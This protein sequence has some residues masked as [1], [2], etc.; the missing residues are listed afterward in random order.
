MHK[1]PANSVYTI[2]TLKLILRL[3]RGHGIDEQHRRQDRAH[4]QEP[5]VAQ[6]VRYYVADHQ[7]NTLEIEHIHSVS[8]QDFKH[9]WNQNKR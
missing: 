7:I 6:T 9:S 2:N 5:P 1:I 4:K 3:E 8:I